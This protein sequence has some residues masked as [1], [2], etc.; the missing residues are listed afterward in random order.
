MKMKA[1]SKL[2]LLILLFSIRCTAQAQALPCTVTITSP[3]NNSSLQGTVLVSVV[4]SC[5]AGTVAFYRAYTE[6]ITRD[7]GDGGFQLDTT[8]FPNG[9]NSITVIAWDSSGLVEEGISA[10]TFFTVSNG[11]PTPPTPTVSFIPTPAPSPTP[12]GPATSCRPS[13]TAPGVFGT[14]VTVKGKITMAFNPGCNGTYGN[15]ELWVGCP[16]S[17][18]R[19]SCAGRQVYTWFEGP[20]S[21]FTFDTTAI[22]DAQ[23]DFGIELFAAD[24]TVLGSVH[25]DGVDHDIVLT[26]AN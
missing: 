10:Q 22:P 3:S 24:G 9:P 16:D 23:Y 1:I 4:N 12:S 18:L 13:W 26:V 5:T 21:S 19:A 14:P 25:Y 6:G 2:V 11:A 17:L 7:F 15:V 20:V 8:A